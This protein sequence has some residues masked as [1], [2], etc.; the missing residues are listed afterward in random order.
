MQEQKSFD[1]R[2]YTVMIILIAINIIIY[3][4]CTYAGEVVYN[5]GCMDAE[6][7]LLDGEYYRF[8]TSM[9]MHGGIDHIVSNMIFLAALGEMLERVIGHARFAILYILS[10]IGGGL[11]SIANVLLSGN[12]HT[13]VGASGAIFG[14]IGAMLILVVIHNGRYQ[15]ISVGRMIFAIVY[16]VYDGMRSEGI[17][18]AAHV[19]GLIFG[20]LIMAFM[21]VIEAFKGNR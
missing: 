3:M 12:H 19:G 21:N 7:V 15:D 18:N 14:L 4:Y 2:D 8:F 20:A 10:G 11:F 17:D 1:Y 16:M 13:S 9:F 6:R 5:R